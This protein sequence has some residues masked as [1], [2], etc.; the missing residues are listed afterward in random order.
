VPAAS[1]LNTTFEPAITVWLAGAVEMK[2][3]THTVS[4]AGALVSAPPTFVI[5]TV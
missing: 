3:G 5:A 4:D 1:T 2:G